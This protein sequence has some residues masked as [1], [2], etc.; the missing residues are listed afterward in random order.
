MDKVREVVDEFRTVVA[1]RVKVVDSIYCR[2][3]ARVD[4]SEAVE[5][6]LASKA[7]AVRRGGFGF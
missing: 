2:P 3:S 1:G 4:Y 6:V 5:A 7:A